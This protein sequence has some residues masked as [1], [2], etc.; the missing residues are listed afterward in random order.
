MKNIYLLLSFILI[1]PIAL[2][3]QENVVTTEQIAIEGQ[4]S[5]INTFLEKA[6]YKTFSNS[7]EFASCQIF[8]LLGYDLA[9]ISL[10]KRI[11]PNPLA[12]KVDFNISKAENAKVRDCNNIASSSLSFEKLNVICDK[13]HYYDMIIERVTFGFPDSIID[14][15]ALNK[16]KL[17]F[18]AGSRIDLKV[19]VSE[20]NL[21]SVMKLYAKSKNLSSVKVQLK[22]DNCRIIGRVKMSFAVAEFDIKGHIKQLSPKTINFISDK[23][24]ING[25]QQP[26]A[27]VNS[28]LNYVNPVFDSTK[29]WMN[30]NITKMELKKGFV[31]TTAS[32]DKKEK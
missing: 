10:I 29:L 1:I 7:H 9:E 14:K 23:F 31:E 11:T 19:E 18:L 30:L 6:F 25:L 17:R 32:I 4:N 26:R 8:Q 27:F 5:A 22:K 20:E 12:L 13:V 15:I 21:L 28:I 2:F 3:G 24:L 16:G